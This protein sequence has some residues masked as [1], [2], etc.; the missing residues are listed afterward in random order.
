MPVWSKDYVRLP[1]GAR[2]TSGLVDPTGLPIV[3]GFTPV[4]TVEPVLWSTAIWE[5]I[6]GQTFG[7]LLVGTG[8]PHGV[9]TAGRFW[10]CARVTDNPEIPVVISTNQ[11][12][13]F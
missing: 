8:S 12:K 7:A 10:V 4:R 2:D 9:M 13:F 6:D 3:M 1:I 11:F 5:F